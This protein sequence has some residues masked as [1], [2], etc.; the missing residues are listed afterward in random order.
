M[1]RI[2]TIKPEF[3]TSEDIVLLSPL[4]RLLYI[5]LWCEADRE[6]RMVWRPGTFRL[7][8]LPGDNCDIEKLCGELIHRGLVK[9]YGD[10]FALIPAFRAHQHVNPRE[11]VSQIPSP[12]NDLGD[13]PGSK[14]G[15]RKPRVD[16][17]SP[18]VPDAQGGREGKGMNNPPTPLAR[19]VGRSRPRKPEQPTAETADPSEAL[20]QRGVAVGV[21]RWTAGTLSDYRDRVQRA[22]ARAA[23]PATVIDIVSAAV[24]SA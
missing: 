17:A 24:R 19:G 10:G 11:S 5:A 20:Q 16:D 12:D 1:A 18:R 8:Y 4:A 21:G 7:R 22:E 6:G 3:F 2:R 9:L 13:P 15:T 14:R 23:A